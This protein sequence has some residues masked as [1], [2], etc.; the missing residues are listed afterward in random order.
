MKMKKLIA[1]TVASF[2]LFTNIAFAVQASIE[3]AFTASES[4]DVIGYKLYARNADSA[5][6]VY[7]WTMDTITC[8]IAGECSFV[9]DTDLPYGEYYFIAT[10]YN[11]QYE[12]VPSNETEKF[13]L[14]KKVYRPLP[15]RNFRTLLDKIIAWL[16]KFRIFKGKSFKIRKG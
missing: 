10:A 6:Y 3:F 5:D 8:D 1:L 2:F 9:L 14:E 16:N 11:D 15:P 12:S 4:T 7:A 13:T